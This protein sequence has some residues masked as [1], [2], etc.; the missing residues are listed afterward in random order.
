[1]TSC[2]I[3]FILHVL[4]KWFT[5]CGS[6]FSWLCRML[7]ATSRPTSMAFSL[8]SSCRSWKTTATFTCTGSFR[9][10]RSGGTV[11]TVAI[12][13][14]QWVI[15]STITSIASLS[16]CS[17]TLSTSHQPP[18]Q[19]RLQVTK[20]ATAVGV[21]IFQKNSSLDSQHCNLSLLSSYLSRDYSGCRSTT[22]LSLVF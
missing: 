13:W 12:L 14:V 11:L 10:L 2:N 4:L 22:S 7:Y 9:S 18:R 1:M 3:N 20:R 6:G 21:A 17:T 19:V 8:Q 5:L 15:Y 16:F